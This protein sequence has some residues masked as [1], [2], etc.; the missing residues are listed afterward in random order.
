MV[1]KLARVIIGYFQY[2]GHRLSQPMWRTLHKLPQG[3]LTEG[4]VRLASSLTLFLVNDKNI[5][6]LGIK[7]K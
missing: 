2:L 3:I 6:I 5:Y 1:K 7:G 4:E